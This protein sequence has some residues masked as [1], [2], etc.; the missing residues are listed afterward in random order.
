MRSILFGSGLAL[1]MLFFFCGRRA[2]RSLPAILAIGGFSQSAFQIILIF[3]F[4]V[5]YGYLFYKLGF[6]FAFFMLG[7]FISG[8]FYAG[9]V[10]PLPEARRMLLKVQAAVA[11][12]SAILPALLYGLAR[13]NYAFIVKSGQSALFPALSLFVGLTGGYVFALSN[14]I[15]LSVYSNPGRAR[16]AGLTYGWDLI[17]GCLGAVICA[18]ILIPVA[19]VTVTCALLA[20]LNLS[21]YLLLSKTSA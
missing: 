13:T 16:V 7:L 21:A 6:L 10:G 8:W 19:G 2:E 5:L 20:A 14:Q 11:I 1:A 15:Y 4:Q 12:F 17:G 3:S 9:R 18:V